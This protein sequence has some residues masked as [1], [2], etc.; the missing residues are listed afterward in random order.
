MVLPNPV[1][2]VY[3]FDTSQQ[4]T[5]ENAYYV[6]MHGLSPL[7]TY[8]SHFKATYI[9]DRIQLYNN[10]NQKGHG[11]IEIVE[12]AKKTSSDI[13]IHS[14]VCVHCCTT[15]KKDVSWNAETHPYH[16]V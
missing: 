5:I 11:Y 7:C 16:T 3:F 4:H 9:Y 1:I 10:L 14:T 8:L 13:G 2:V 15:L 6:H 12:K